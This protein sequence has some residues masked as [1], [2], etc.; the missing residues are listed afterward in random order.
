MAIPTPPTPLSRGAGL[1]LA[2]VAREALSVQ[3][4]LGALGAVVLGRSD[5]GDPARQVSEIALA[6]VP[7]AA[8]VSVMLTQQERVRTMAFAGMGVA[9]L[10]ERLRALGPGPARAAARTGRTV[11]VS[12]SAT[13]PAHPTCPDYAA[14]AARVGVSAVTCLALSAG[15]HS[16]GALSLCCTRAGSGLDARDLAAAA[17]IAERAGVV[18]VNAW[19]YD[20]AVAEAADLRAAMVS[21]EVIDLAKGVLIARTAVAPEEAFAQLSRASR[22]TNRKVSAIAADIVATTR[23]PIAGQARPAPDQRSTWEPPPGPT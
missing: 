18:L 14:A 6:A 3:A 23:H 22:H 15:G 19:R 9:A 5:L 11:S 1:P 8:G 4:A 10:D 21:R 16:V 2:P 7:G 13:G 17:A 20:Q 12:T